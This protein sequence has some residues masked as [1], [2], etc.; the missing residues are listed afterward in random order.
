MR[1]VHAEEATT[2]RTQLFDGDH[3][4]SRP[5]CDLLFC[6]FQGGHGTATI[7][8]HRRAL[9]HQDEGCHQ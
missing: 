9:Q 4:R 6:S 5:L 7:E 3:G 2:V 8:G 1:T